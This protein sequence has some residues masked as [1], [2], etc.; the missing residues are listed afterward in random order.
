PDATKQ[1]VGL[2][3]AHHYTDGLSF[4]L[5]AT[6]SNNTADAPSGF[7]SIDPGQEESYDAERVTKAF[8]PGDGSNADVLN[9]A[10]G[11]PPADP[12][13]V[14]LANAAAQEQ[15]DA[16]H[17]NRAV[18]P[19]TMGYFLLQMMGVR[20]ESATPLGVDDLRWARQH[21]ID[22]VRASGP[23]P[24][25]RVGRQPYGL[26][27]TTSLSFWKPKAGKEQDYARDVALQDLLVKL[28]ELWRRNL[29][30]VPRL[31]RGENPDQD[32]ADVLGMEA[33]SSN[34]AARHLLGEAYIQNLWLA[35]TT[36]TPNPWWAKQQ[37]LTLAVLRTL[38]LDWHPN[39]SKA[40][41]SGWHK[42]I[43]GPTTQ[44]EIPNE[45]APLDPDFIQMLLTAPDVETMRLEKFGDP[46]P[47]GLL[48]VI[49]RHALLLEYWT[50]AANLNLRDNPIGLGWS[51]NREQEIQKLSVMIPV[52]Q[53]QNVWE[54]LGA[55]L[56]GV[57]DQ[58]LGTFLHDL[59]SS[60]DPNIAP[61]VA[62]LFEF[63]E[64]LAYLQTLSAAKLQ[65]TFAGTLDLCS[66]RLDAWITSL[67]TKRLA[68]MR[69]ENQ[70]GNLLGG[71]GW[72]MNLK[73]GA[74][75]T[76]ETTPPGEQGTFFRPA[77]N[78]GFTQAPSLGQAATVAVLRSG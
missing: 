17:M 60:A 78:P 12:T 35:V 15:V 6:P 63:R 44:F 67:A 48:Y 10:L 75:S 72:V 5:N 14:H 69:K 28:R 26:L 52:P 43:P 55:P 58:P 30:Q 8:K 70:S 32:F 19:A 54:L 65:R 21:F 25:L 42:Q 59:K 38:G 49:L 41:Y 64:S 77:N 1:L 24:A 4:L 9:T 18:S 11:L 31:G 33:L 3:N 61:H 40:T 7:S 16:R 45:T 76:V 51:L 27:P 71:Y 36:D 29:F 34:Y 73:P 50:A 46:K 39:L 37:E 56:A 47:R 23:L 20:N 13:L 53:F 22:Y 62:T 66:H 74:A 68:G 2:L 57:T